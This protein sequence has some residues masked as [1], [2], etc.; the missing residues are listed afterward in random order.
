MKSREFVTNEDVARYAKNLDDETAGQ[1]FKAAC[2]LATEGQTTD[3]LEGT[4][5]DMLWKALRSGIVPGEPADSRV[6]EMPERFA[7]LRK[8][9]ESQ[10]MWDA[11]KEANALLKAAL[12]LI[13]GETAEGQILAVCGCEQAQFHLE[14]AL[15][16][17]DDADR[18]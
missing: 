17:L 11:L 7:R 13:N 3:F 9:M 2:R 1:L 18:P 10:E 8:A 12:P 15:E 5:V 6:S 4:A 14:C 16:M